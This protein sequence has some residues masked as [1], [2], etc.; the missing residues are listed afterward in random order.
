MHLHFH[1]P[2]GRAGGRALVHR[3]D[4][5]QPRGRAQHA[6]LERADP[7]HASD[8]AAVTAIFPA[9]PGLGWSV[10]KAPRFATRIQKAV[11]GR[12]LRVLDQPYPIWTWTLTYALLRDK[13]DTRGAGRARRR[14]RRIAHARRLFPAAAGR[15]PALPVRRPDRRRR[16]RPADRHRQCAAPRVFQ[17]VRTH[18]RLHRAD[19]RAQ[20]G[21][22]RSISTAC[23][24][25]AAGY[26]VDRRHRPGDV[27]GAA[28]RRPG[29]SPP[30]SPIGSACASPTT[31]PNSRTSCTSCG[32]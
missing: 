5:A 28:A 27:R 16:H 17:L 7:A 25:S 4:G 22:A 31:P 29:A 14:L 18:G 9:L 8:E 30:T 6:A 26:S 20:H 23:C 1:G 15:L 19:H 10:T 21:R 2:G 32:S 3:A 11:S 12:E 24:R 13:W